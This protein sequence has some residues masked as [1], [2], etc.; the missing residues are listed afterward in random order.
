MKNSVA[1][2]GRLNIFWQLCA[3]KP[4][5][6]ILHKY[7]IIQAW[8]ENAED[9]VSTPWGK[10]TSYECIISGYMYLCIYNRIM[11]W[12]VHSSIIHR[13]R[14]SLSRFKSV[15]HPI[16]WNSTVP[17]Q[18]SP[19]RVVVEDHLMSVFIRLNL[20]ACGVISGVCLRVHIHHLTVTLI[21]EQ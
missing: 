7:K 17:S 3:L 13:H 6:F 4:T 14:H 11:F 9:E 16:M 1:N 8:V 19:G 10:T 15:W 5:T 18:S 21:L 2:V 20:D 12:Y